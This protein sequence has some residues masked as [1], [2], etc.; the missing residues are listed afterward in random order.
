MAFC[1]AQPVAAADFGYTS[2]NLSRNNVFRVGTTITQGGAMRLSKEKLSLLKGAEISGAKVCFGSKNS[3][4]SQAT[5]FIATS[6]DGEPVYK[7]TVSISG[8][9]TKWN[10]YA[11]A[12]PYIIKGDEPE[13]YIGFTAEG[14]NDDVKMLSA[15][16]TADIAGCSYAYSEG[17]WLDMFGM[18]FGVINVRATIDK[19][20]ETTDL[21]VKTLNYNGYYKE[22]EEYAFSGQVFNFGTKPVTSYDIELSLEGSQPQTISV[23][24]VNV[25]PGAVADFTLPAYVAETSGKLKMSVAAKNVNG[26]AD[27]DEADNVSETGMFFYPED[28]ERNI[29]LECFT[30]QACG[31]C[32]NGHQ[33]VHSFLEDAVGDPVIEV[34]HHIGYQPDFYTMEEDA[35]YLTFYGSA[36]TF[37]PAFMMNRGVY[38]SVSSFPAIFTEASSLKATYAAAH[39][40]QPYAKLDLRTGYDPET[41]QLNVKLDITNVNDLPEGT[42]V[43]NVVL[44]QDGMV[45]YQSG[46]GSNYVHN[47]VF[48]GSLT[49]NAWGFAISKTN[50][51]EVTSWAN[52]IILP[53]SIISDYDKT[54]AAAAPM[55]Y[56]HPAIPENMSVV[57][58]V[59][60]FSANSYSGHDI[61]NCV[62]VPLAGDMSSVSDAISPAAEPVV[63]VEGRSIV[64]EGE[65]SQ[66]QVY[67]MMGRAADASC[68]PAAGVYVV[69]VSHAGG[70]TA[71]KVI[72]K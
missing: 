17:K 30:G 21:V 56:G 29:L 59:G 1:A 53:D 68:L 34:M 27:S 18:G 71:K 11:F 37:A 61:Y 3:S 64:V 42:N 15:D 60:G 54:A 46:G 13:L 39:E 38:S 2:G 49:G 51:G 10:E 4:G 16:M 66:V 67:D 52:S 20:P 24:N 8:V 63:K 50:A 40:K 28:M 45:G 41:R 69:R 35:A 62:K 70:V 7:Q 57:A 6:L 31:N 65:C 26:G 47:G 55:A 43:F 72:V 9:A 36:G 12:T 22:G 32:P 58:Y 33:N 23:S 44:I 14:T 25:A 48:R 5:L 19:A